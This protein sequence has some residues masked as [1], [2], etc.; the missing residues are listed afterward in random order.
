MMIQLP[1]GL[2]LP[3]GIKVQVDENKPQQIV[4]ETCDLKGCYGTAP[5]S[6]EMLGAMKAGKR[7]AVSFQNAAKQNIAI[8]F[9]LS[10]FAETYQHVQ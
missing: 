8:P 3:A 7:F 5:V 1:V 4:L 2:F 10:N 6:D 9:G